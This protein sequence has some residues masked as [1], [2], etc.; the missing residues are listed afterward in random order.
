MNYYET[1]FEY[2]LRGLTHISNTTD[3]NNTC[4]P[5]IGVQQSNR[6]PQGKLLKLNL[7]IEDTHED[8]SRV[9]VD[10]ILAGL[11]ESGRFV[12]VAAAGTTPTRTYELLGEQYQQTPDWFVDMVV[13]KLDEWCG[14]A[15][16]APET[17]DTYMRKHVVQPLG[18]SRDCY[19]AFD[20]NA[21]SSQAECQR[22]QTEIARRGPVDLCVL[23]LGVNGHLGLNEPS[24][25][26]QLPS[27]VAT[28][29]ESTR[30]HPMLSRATCRPTQGMTVG[31]EGIMQSKQIILLVSGARKKKPFHSF[32]TSKLTP[33]FPATYIREH[34]NLLVICNREALS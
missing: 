12:M 25:D 21:S 30:S 9:A 13:I 26:W 6:K 29:D 5:S 27:H 18:I 11:R 10:R 31:M 15:M 4:E 28:L 17:C 22:V 33:R 19:I 2:E 14:L 23:G 20:S 3:I 34:N 32:L 24:D 1:L 8:M 7:V 16:D